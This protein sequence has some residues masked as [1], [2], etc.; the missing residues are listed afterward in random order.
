M[1]I[2]KIPPDVLERLVFNRRGAPRREVLV[3]P[4]IGED[5]A[6]IDLGGYYLAI[7]TDPIS[8]SIKLLGYLAV[9]VP[10]NDIAV[11]GIPPMWL[12]IA[13][14]FPPETDETLLDEVTK[15][16]DLAAREVNVAIVG[17]H[18][19]VTS[20]VGRPVAIATAIGVGRRYISTSGAKPGDVVFMTKSAGQETASILATDFEN[21][22]LKKG[23]NKEVLDRAKELAKAVSVLRE[24]LALADLA[25]SMHDPTEGGIANGLA[26]IAYAS[27]VSI[28]VDPSKVIVYREVE[29]LCSAFGI[30]PLET[31]SS[32]VLLA[33]LPPNSVQE[34][35]E[36]LKKL[37]I[38][39]SQIGRVTPR[40]NFLVKIGDRLYKEPYVRDRLF[41]LF[42]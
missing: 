15:Q 7:H 1:K 38:P 27:G 6:I 9:Y 29:E 4:A 21:E 8:G 26:E 24:A 2:G 37:G 28:E 11:R 41:S 3:G 32:G 18:T 10:T 13:L 31:L 12:S 40:G 36:R 23:I 17:G 35:E 25:T 34:A 42:S 39:Y 30:D 19:E 14:L 5:A 33:T 16:I 20:A 22:A